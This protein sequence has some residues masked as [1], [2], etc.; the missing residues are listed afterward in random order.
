M[1]VTVQVRG[2]EQLKGRAVALVG[3][4]GGS[5]EKQADVV[6]QQRHGRER[7]RSA[8]FRPL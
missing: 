4:H 5:A 8:A 1:K 2:I 6:D 3:D 7:R